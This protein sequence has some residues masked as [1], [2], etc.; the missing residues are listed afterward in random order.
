MK[1]KPLSD[2][3][4]VKPIEEE[5]KVRGGII[6]PDTAK[7]RPQQGEIIAVG[8]GKHSESGDIIE[9]TVKVG[10]KVLYSKFAGNEVTIEGEKHLIMRESDLLAILE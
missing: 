8:E 9:P 3:V 10:E 6:I 1:V 2:R 5:E 7:E 4:L